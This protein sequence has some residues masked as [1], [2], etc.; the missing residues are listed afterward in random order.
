MRLRVISLCLVSVLFAAAP[1]VSAE[2]ATPAWL[3]YEEGNLLYENREFGRALQRYKDAVAMA[4]I[5]PEAEAAIGD[6]YREEGELE[7]ARKQYEKAYNHKNSLVVPS[8][9]YDI[10]YRLASIYRDQELYKLMEDTLQQILA[11]DANWG[12]GQST[13]L[14]SQIESNYFTKGM[15]QVL[16]LYRFDASFAEPAH[17]QLGWFYYR[18]G[19]FPQAV[20]HCLYA[21][22]YT[23][24]EAARYLRERDVEWE[25]T[26]FEKLLE[27]VDGER[28][29]R[30]FVAQSGLFKD[31]YYLAGSSYAVMY[32][33]LATSLWK[34]ISISRTAGEYAVLS[35]QQLK[36]PWIEPYLVPL[37]KPAVKP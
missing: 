13:R 10:L 9:R 33:R 18:T 14:R 19:R 17:A 8:A 15:D 26:S 20:Q 31:L 1:A 23:A 3:L 37:K 16:R 4:G 11:D 12:K 6:V 7:L 32:P 2:V 22:M 36:K 24:S 5:L 27:A 35:K 34:L 28:E 21:V 29:L 30:D 25:F